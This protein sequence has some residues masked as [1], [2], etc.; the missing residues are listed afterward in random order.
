MLTGIPKRAATMPQAMIESMAAVIEGSVRDAGSTM[1]L[2][3]VAATA[4]PLM[5]PSVFITTAIIIASLGD[6]TPVEIT[7]AMALGASV[8]PLINSA[9]STVNSAMARPTVTTSIYASLRASERIS[10]PQ[11]L[12]SSVISSSS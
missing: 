10:L 7:V 11:R 9:A 1:P 6:M 5:A 2:P 3:T 8:Q 4:V 12:A